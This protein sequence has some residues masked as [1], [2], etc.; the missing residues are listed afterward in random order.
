VLCVEGLYTPC[1]TKL[2][3]LLIQNVRVHD[4][5]KNMLCFACVAVQSSYLMNYASSVFFDLT[6][7]IELQFIL[8][9]APCMLLQYYLPCIMILRKLASG[10]Q[11]YYS[12]Y[13]FM[14]HVQRCWGITCI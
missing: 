7:K 13:Y 4:L 3:S 9:S 14:M 8:F 6:R 2:S 5:E 1:C 12:D 10:I 11:L